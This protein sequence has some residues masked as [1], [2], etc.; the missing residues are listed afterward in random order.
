[1]GQCGNDDDER[2]ARYKCITA[3]EKHRFGGVLSSVDVVSNNGTWKYSLIAEGF[4]DE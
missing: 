3:C 1:M 2:G 4:I